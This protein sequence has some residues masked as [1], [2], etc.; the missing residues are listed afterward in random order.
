MLLL[1]FVCHHSPLLRSLRTL[2]QKGLRRMN[3]MG[4]TQSLSVISSGTLSS[5]GKSFLHLHSSGS[6]GRIHLPCNADA[7]SPSYPWVQLWLVFTCPH[8]SKITKESRDGQPKPIK[9]LYAL[10]L[11]DRIMHLSMLSCMPTVIFSIGVQIKIDFCLRARKSVIFNSSAHV[12][13]NHNAYGETFIS[14]EALR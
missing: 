10:I 7:I 8:L 12:Q 6:R 2:S 11:R 1:Q 4:V 9:I 3:S 5:W 13:Y 14:T